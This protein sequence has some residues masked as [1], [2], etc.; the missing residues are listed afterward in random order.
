VSRVVENLNRLKGPQP[1]ELLGKALYDLASY[2]LF[3]AR[4]QLRRAQ[5]ARDRATTAP[6]KRHVSQ[7]VAAML[8]P[9]APAAPAD[10]GPGK[11]K[12]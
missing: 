3:L 6:G 5:E 12:T 2:A 8:E 7:R 11:K 1:E 10:R 4:P 9:I